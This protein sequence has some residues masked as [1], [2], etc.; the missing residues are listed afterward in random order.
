[1]KLALLSFDF[2]GILLGWRLFDHAA[3]LGG[4]VFGLWYAYGGAKYIVMIQK[5]LIQKWRRI[6]DDYEKSKPFKGKED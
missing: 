6:R 3:H 4:A 2:N 1:V 5:H